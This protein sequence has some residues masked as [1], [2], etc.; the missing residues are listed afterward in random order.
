M[1]KMRALDP[2]LSRLPDA[3]QLI[4]DYS[5]LHQNFL[6][7]LEQ[8]HFRSLLCAQSQSVRARAAR[9]EVWNVM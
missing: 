2:N 4:P 9:L 3:Y 5:T 6:R 8:F 1:G 7:G